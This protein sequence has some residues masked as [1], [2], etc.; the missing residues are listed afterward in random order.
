MTSPATQ[1]NDSAM[2]TAMPV[3][4][5]LPRPFPCS[6]VAADMRSVGGKTPAITALA[7]QKD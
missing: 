3:V 7:S 2:T 6:P 4:G 5:I 1:P